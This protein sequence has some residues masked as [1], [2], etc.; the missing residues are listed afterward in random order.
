MHPSPFGVKLPSLLGGEERLLASIEEGGP[1]MRRAIILL[2]AMGLALVVASGVAWA[3]VIQCQA[4][5]QCTGTAGPDSMYGSAGND[6]MFAL[7]GNDHLVGKAGADNLN[8]Q[9]GADLVVA[10]PGNDWA[11]GGDQNDTVRGDK[12][13]DSLTGGSGHDVIQAV[14]GMRD[15]IYCGPGSRDRVFYDRGLD[16]F[17]GCEFRNAR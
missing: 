10:G 15:L 2:T 13:N 7:P 16:H 3:A 17:R 9:D 14:D 8:G 12:G 5:R 11:K 1:E 6:T 4:N